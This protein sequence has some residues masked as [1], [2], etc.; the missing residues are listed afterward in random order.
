MKKLFLFL[1]AILFLGKCTPPETSPE[2]PT[3][4]KEAYEDAFFIGSALN[5]AIV[6]GTDKASQDIV[7]QQFNTITAEN[8]MKAGPINPEPGVYN[9]QPADE[10]VAFGE[11]NDLF[12]IGHTLVWHNQTPAWFFQD[13]SGNLNTPEAFREQRVSKE[14]GCT[15]ILHKK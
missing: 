3:T 2:T 5:E 1:I 6:S 11:E 12:I 4:L 10:Y 13:E 14:G 9:F 8:V 7:L 15:E